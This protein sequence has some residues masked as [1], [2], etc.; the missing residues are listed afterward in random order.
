MSFYCFIAIP[1]VKHGSWHL[2]RHG[3]SGSGSSSGGGSSSGSGSSSASSSG[4]CEKSPGCAALGLN[5]MCCPNPGGKGPVAIRRYADGFKRFKSV[6]LLGPWNE[7]EGFVLWLWLFSRS[8][9]LSFGT[10]LQRIR[11]MSQKKQLECRPRVC[12][13]VFFDLLERRPHFL[14]DSLVILADWYF[15]HRELLMLLSVCKL[16]NRTGNMTEAD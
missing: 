6:S 2:C 4:A 3:S 1:H 11:Q 16:I 9:H 10:I 12:P 14:V 15:P 8:R 13:T 7:Q 5:G